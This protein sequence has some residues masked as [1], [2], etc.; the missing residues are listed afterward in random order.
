[1]NLLAIETA[2]RVCSVAITRDGELIA[3]YR[4]NL[5]NIHAERLFGAIGKILSDTNLQ[6][7]DLGAIAV[8]S[9]PGSFTGLRIGVAAAKGL[10]FAN[11]V[12]LIGI[13]TL[14]AL[15]NQAI[16]LGEYI[17][18]VLHA[19]ATQIYAALFEREGFNLKKIKPE[20]ILDL[21]ELERFIL[22]NTVIFGNGTDKLKQLDIA[23][24]FNF[25]PDRFGLASASMIAQ[26]AFEKYRK[27]EFE[28]L[29]SFEPFYLQDFIASKRKRN[30]VLN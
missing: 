27:N 15:A 30:R 25:V 14:S 11:D 2:T 18:P 28:D 17:C 13:P 26:M 6:T 3:E 24:K 20:T 5:K 1:M 21:V 8:S 10:A 16:G 9:G 12:P 22:P 23:D 7:G 4:L 29:L 19:R